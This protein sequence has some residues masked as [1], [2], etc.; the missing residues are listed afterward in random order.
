MKQY[1]PVSNQ[2]TITNTIQ[3]EM[4]LLGQPPLTRY[5][6]FVK[7]FGVD[8][9]GCDRARLVRE[10]SGAN[11]YYDELEEREAGI[12]DALECLPLPGQ[13]RA[14]AGKLMD[15]PRFR[16]TFDSLPT[17]LE[18]V[19]LDRLVICQNHVNRDF[20]DGLKEGLGPSPGPSALFDF[21]QPSEDRWPAVQMRE[22][23]FRHYSFRSDSADLRLHESALLRADQLQGHD[24]AGTVSGAVGVMVGFSS[25]CL[26]AIR[27]DDN[28]RLLLNNGYHRAVALLELGITHAPCVVQTVTR[29]DELDLTAK[30]VVARDPGYFFNGKRPPLLKDY[31]DPRIA[32]TFP[33]RKVSRVI[34][35]HV[36][37]R[38]FFAPD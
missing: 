31:L 37:V 22:H 36:E 33:I 26:N 25:N 9:S 20:V 19:R 28:G 27:D 17:H 15:A 6:D 11:D 13:M 21:C 14:Q 24:T 3:R 4:W 1:E 16:Y 5:L 7:G 10:W 32:K 29:R 30:A 12:A 35:V 18:M 38:E 34:E 8:G 2:A 23:G